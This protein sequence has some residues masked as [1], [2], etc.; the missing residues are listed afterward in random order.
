MVEEEGS[1]AVVRTLLCGL[2]RLWAAGQQPTPIILGE[3][4]VIEIETASSTE[5]NGGP[6]HHD[7]RLSAIWETRAINATLFPAT[8]I[9]TARAEIHETVPRQQDRHIQTLPRL[10]LDRPTVAV[11]L[12][13]DEVAE[14]LRVEDGPS[15]PTS[16]IDITIP[17]I[18][19][20]DLGV[21]RRHLYAESG[22]FERS[23]ATIATLTDGNATTGDLRRESTILILVPPA[24]RSLVCVQ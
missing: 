11:A 10:A 15:I 5:E 19:H 23:G 7:A 12:G 16:G 4:T 3:L 8:S 17:G 21:V 9:S 22:T 13:A 2:R 20:G 18:V 14:T 24:L 1:Q 6:L